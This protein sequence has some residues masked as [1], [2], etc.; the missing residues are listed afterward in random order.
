MTLGEKAQI[1]H[2][3]DQIR[4]EIK[5]LETQREILSKKYPSELSFEDI[6]FLKSVDNTIMEYNYDM[7]KLYEELN[8]SRY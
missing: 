8:D 3:M 7:R 6:K 2:E 1:F 4:N 5:R